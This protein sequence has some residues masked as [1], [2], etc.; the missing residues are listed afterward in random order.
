MKPE[1]VHTAVVAD[2]IE[3]VNPDVDVAATLKSATP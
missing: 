2:N 3:T 1:I